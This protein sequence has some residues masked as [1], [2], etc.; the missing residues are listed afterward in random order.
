MCS[1]FQLG[2]AF[3][4]KIAL[5]NGQEAM[6]KDKQ[7]CERRAMLPLYGKWLG[8]RPARP[9]LVQPENLPMPWMPHC[10]QRGF[11]HDKAKS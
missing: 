9:L 2:W 5:G 8:R 1:T 3:R 6:G 11:V 7:A 10:K 4:R